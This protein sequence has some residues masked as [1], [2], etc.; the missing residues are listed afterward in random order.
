MEKKFFYPAPGRS[1]R[2]SKLIR[3]ERAYVA[4]LVSFLAAVLSLLGA[5]L[6]GIT[7]G[8]NKIA[9]QQ[10]DQLQTYYIADAGVEYA[11][12]R[13]V[14]DPAWIDKL[15]LNVEI[16][17]PDQNFAGGKV[18]TK[19]KKIGVNESI[20]NLYIKSTGYYKS[21]K[22]TLEARVTI[23]EGIIAVTYWQE[24]YHVFPKKPGN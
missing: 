19:I 12:A 15:G 24:K 23:K 5:S 7:S 8:E 11:L 13:V 16:S 2:T 3:S 21:C 4:I 14:A 17:L 6:L 20:A 9:L 10:A 18:E 1:G 22:R